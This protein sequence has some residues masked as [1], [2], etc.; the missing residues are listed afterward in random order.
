MSKKNNIANRIIGIDIAR[1]LAIFGMI[2][3]NFKMVLG[4]KGNGWEYHFSEF[5]S[6][7]AAALFV[8]LAGTGLALMS[9]NAIAN[10]DL[11]KQEI[12]R[13]NIFKRALLLFLIG[14]SYIWIWPADILHFYG[15]YMLISLWF[16]RKK[17][18]TIF[19]GIAFF[20]LLF[21]VL[22]V[23]LPYEKGWDFVTLDYQ[24]FWSPIGFFRNLFYNGFHPVIPWV[25][26]ML[27]GLWL[28]KKDLNNLKVI[29]KY[30]GYSLMIF[31]LIQLLSFLLQTFYTPANRTIDWEQEIWFFTTSP[32][33][34]LP[35]YLINGMSFATFVLTGSIWLGKKCKDNHFIHFLANTGKLALSFYIIHVVIGMVL[36][37]VI[38]SKSLG[39]FSI[40][41]SVRYA[42]L[43]CIFC[44]IFANIWLK[45][46]KYGPFEWIMNKILK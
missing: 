35:L 17:S 1:A 44:S 10:N 28:G 11:H 43:F 9:N 5:L 38:T 7:K 39:Q 45:N 23:L 30:F 13:K 20:T 27:Y 12:I 42:L 8:V 22:L 41:F 31:L 29:K 18:S 3:V 14:L 6:G 24:D 46:K 26:F 25:S 4:S 2:V 21:P 40:Q 32:M 19:L 33:P 37:E 16:L 36:P 34:P 15:I